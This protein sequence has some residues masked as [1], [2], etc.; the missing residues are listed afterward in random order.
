[1]DTKPVPDSPPRHPIGPGDSG[2]RALV[3][4]HRYRETP[5]SD[6][7]ELGLEERLQLA[8]LGEGHPPD[9][10][11][12]QGATAPAEL[13]VQQGL[14]ELVEGVVAEPR[15]V[16]IGVPRTGVGSVDD[17]VSETFE[18]PRF[19]RE[20]VGRTEEKDAARHVVGRLH[21]S[22]RLTKLVIGQSGPTRSSDDGRRRHHAT[23]RKHGEHPECVADA[24]GFLAA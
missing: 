12:G 21:K 22:E 2:G 8:L 7:V 24:R 17:P 15:L 18:V 13:T 14:E 10:E 11:L 23:G 4:I 16:E 6:H 1:M 19:A 5:E 20:G 3:A 9:P